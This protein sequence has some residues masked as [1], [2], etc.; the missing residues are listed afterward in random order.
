MALYIPQ[1]ALLFLQRGDD[2][3]TGIACQAFSDDNFS[4]K[5]QIMVFSSSVEDGAKV[6]E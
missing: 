1:T 4:Q 6:G 5:V 2:E 3:A